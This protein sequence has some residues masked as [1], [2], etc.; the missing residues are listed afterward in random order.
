MSNINPS[1]KSIR[2]D[3]RAVTILWQENGIEHESIIYRRSDG[4]FRFDP[5]TRACGKQVQVFLASAY[6]ESCAKLLNAAKQKSDEEYP[7]FRSE[8]ARIEYLL[9]KE[10]MYRRMCRK[11]NAAAQNGAR[12][13][14]VIGVWRAE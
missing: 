2:V 1:I 7:G 12:N 6:A 10:E 4:S 11:A 5:E 14:S 8:Y 9:K 13:R 3:T